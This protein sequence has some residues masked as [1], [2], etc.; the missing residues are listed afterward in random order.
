MLT[1]VLDGLCGSSKGRGILFLDVNLELT[2][3]EDD[4]LKWVVQDF[5][6]G[7]IDRLPQLSQHNPY[8]KLV[9]VVSIHRRLPK[10]LADHLCCQRSQLSHTK[11]LK[12]PQERW[13]EVNIREWLCKSSGLLRDQP[14]HLD[15]E[16]L[17]SLAQIIFEETDGVPMH[18]ERKLLESLE[19]LAS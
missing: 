10:H 2:T 9:G 14:E 19:R 18:T 15:T 13:L 3:F 5:W 16:R 6:C 11:L 17:S 12:L 1:A 8:I 7:L 4:F